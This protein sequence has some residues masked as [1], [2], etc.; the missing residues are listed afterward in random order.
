MSRR[1][2][3]RRER[4][5]VALIGEGLDTEQISAKL[6]LSKW[7]VRDKIRR[8][9]RENDCPMRELPQKVQA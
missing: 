5:I 6:M 2:I 8:L 4:E 9:C 1:R 3:S 7:T